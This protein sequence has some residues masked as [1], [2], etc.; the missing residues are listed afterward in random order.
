D[1]NGVSTGGYQ[2]T[3][4][5]VVKGF[6]QTLYFTP[7]NIRPGGFYAIELFVIGL[8]DQVYTQRFDQLGQSFHRYDATAPGAVNA[9]LTGNLPVTTSPFLFV[10]G[11]DKQ[12][13]T[14]PIDVGGNSTGGYVSTRSGPVQW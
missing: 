7:F 4:P 13:Y 12:I 14:Q 5:G 10:L 1:L 8:D 11:K 9:L 2:L 6:S 3:T